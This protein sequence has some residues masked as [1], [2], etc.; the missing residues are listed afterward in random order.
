MSSHAIGIDLGTTHSC[1]G[2]YR[3]GKVEI[4]ANDQGSR[5]TPSYVAFTDEEVFV[6]GPAKDIALSHPES[7]IYVN[8]ISVSDIKRLIGRRYADE[9][10]QSDIKTWPFNVISDDGFPKVSIN[11]NGTEK[12][13]KPE[14]ISAMVLKKMKSTAE[15]YL[16]SSVDKAVITVP[17]YFTDYQRQATLE[18]GRMAGFDAVRLMNEPTAAAATYAALQETMRGIVLIYDLGGGTLDISIVNVTDTHCSVNATHG[19]TH[20]G[21]EDF[22]NNLVKYMISICENKYKKNVKNNKR[23]ISRLRHHCE[24]AKKKLSFANSVTIVIDGLIDGIDFHELLTRSKFNELNSDLFKSTLEPITEALKSAKIDKND[25]DKIIMVGGSARIPKLKDL[26]MNFFDGKEIHASINPDEAIAYG[27]SIYAAVC[28]GVNIEDTSH[29]IIQ[30]IIPMS[31]G[32]GSEENFETYKIVTKKHTA[33]PSSNVRLFRTFDDNQT[34]VE[35]PVYEG[36]AANAKENIFLGKFLIS[37]I[38]A[39]PK[40]E[41]KFD[42]TFSID[43]NGVLKVTAKSLSTGKEADVK[44]LIGRRYADESVQSDIKTWPFNVISDDGFP[45]VV[46]NTNGTE[47]TF[48]PED[49]SAMVLKKMKSTAEAY[50]E[51]SVDKAVITVPAYFTDYQRQATLEAGRLAGLDVMRIANEPTA[52]AVAYAVIKEDMRGTVL[53]Y[54][55]GGGTLDISI[56]KVTDTHC[57]VKATHGNTHLGGEDFSNNLVDYMIGV[58]ENKN[59]CESAKKK[60][61]FADSVNIFIDC[62]VDGIDFNETLTR[63]KFNELNLDVFKST[64]EPVKEALKSAQI[65]KNDVD[66]IIMVGGS[67][68]IPKLKTLL[69]QFFNT[70]EVHTSI[71]PDEAIAYGASIYA[72]FCNGVDI[73]DKNN[74]IIEDIIPMSLGIAARHNDRNDVFSVVIKKHASIPSSVVSRY[75]TADDNQTTVAFRVYEGEATNVKENNL[76]GTFSIHGIPPRPK[77]QEEFDVTFS[78]DINGVLK[79]SAINLSTGIGKSITIDRKF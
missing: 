9:S 45:K 44:R 19:N 70:K 32:I 2:V 31:L 25:V 72:A 75:Y 73:R 54:D 36:E 33:I 49:I 12:T 23:A 29:H 28:N 14:D 58:C 56:V 7:T 20:L 5:T 17:A 24:D 42:V 6:G 59:H 71:N 11:T 40:G 16:E 62:L 61:S 69:Q 21:G 50:L 66:K 53:I 57:V 39:R 38:P 26:L 22:N 48:K 13:F 35:F 52:A 30:E 60:L 55:L 64:L 46:I 74:I 41:E 34:S 68:R 10:V 79:V 37:D 76:L 3:F 43:I 4:I 78:I 65:D 1:V 8:D 27:A 77:G 47:K 51:S 63:P 15:A 18:A 67:S